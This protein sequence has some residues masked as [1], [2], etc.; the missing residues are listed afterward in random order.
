MPESTRSKAKKAQAKPDKY[1]GTNEGKWR[2]DNG[3]GIWTK[4][5]KW[6]SPL[7][8]IGTKGDKAVGFHSIHIIGER[9]WR[10]IQTCM[11]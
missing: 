7:E 11:Y 9:G 5:G 6:K 1:G 4:W 3:Y 10:K 8:I 2:G